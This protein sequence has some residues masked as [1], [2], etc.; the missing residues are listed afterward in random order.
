MIQTI[1]NIKCANKTFDFA[2]R[3]WKELV[4]KSSLVRLK[5]IFEIKSSKPPRGI[6]HTIR[7]PQEVRYF[8]ERETGL[9]VKSGATL[10]CKGDR[11]RTRYLSDSQEA[12]RDK[13]GASLG[14][15]EDL[16]GQSPEFRG[17]RYW[18]E[19]N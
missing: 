15:W 2:K 8:N 3:E 19:K 7:P 17:R 5:K 6:A 10:N 4:V 14:S 11:Q 12:M 13:K 18:G 16:G 9:I 1:T